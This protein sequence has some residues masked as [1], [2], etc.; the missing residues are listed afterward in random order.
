[1]KVKSWRVMEDIDGAYVYPIF[2]GQDQNEAADNMAFGRVCPIARVNEHAPIEI[3]REFCGFVNGNPKKT[4][5]VSRALR[6]QRE[7]EAQSNAE[8]RGLR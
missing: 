8:A 1:M 5:R 4:R 2:E 6:L 3:V 7:H